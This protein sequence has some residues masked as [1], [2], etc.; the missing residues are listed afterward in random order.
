MK[1]QREKN[2]RYL[3]E[4]NVVPELRFWSALLITG[5]SICVTQQ[6]PKKHWKVLRSLYKSLEQTVCSKTKCALFSGLSHPHDSASLTP[7]TLLDSSLQLLP[8]TFLL[9]SPNLNP[10]NHFYLQAFSV[11]NQCN[12][13]LFWRFQSEWQN[14]SPKEAETV[15]NLS[16]LD[17]E[18]SGGW[19]QSLNLYVNI[20]V[21]STGSKDLS[22]ERNSE[23]IIN[24]RWWHRIKFQDVCSTK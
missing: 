22:D 19:L 3:K 16:F 9:C 20:S 23:E 11:E 2:T 17:L 10:Y 7:T 6:S 13:S 21:L 4:T 15:K 8:E 24:I 18:V 1:L 12:M 14:S 5:L